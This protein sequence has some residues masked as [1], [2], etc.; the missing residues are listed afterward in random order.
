MP[1]PAPA[2]EGGGSNE[3]SEFIER[4]LEIQNKYQDLVTDAFQ[5]DAEFQKAMTEA[6][7]EFVNKQSEKNTTAQLIS[8]YVDDFLRERAAQQPEESVD[9]RFEEILR[10]LHHVIDRD[11]FQEFYRKQLAKR[12]LMG[13]SA[14]NEDAE[15]SFIL[16]LKSHNG[17][18][19]TNRLEGMFTDH[20]MASELQTDFNDWVKE[21]EM[22][23]SFEVQ[24]L[25]QGYW[26]S[27]KSDELVLPPGM[28]KAMDLFRE[29][30]NS[31][32]KNR[33]LTWVHTLGTAILSVRTAKGRPV[34]VTMTTYQGVVLLLFN[35]GATLTARQVAQL[36]KL[37][38]KEVEGILASLAYH[39]KAQLLTKTGEEENIAE[40]DVFAFNKG[41]TST[42]RHLKLPGITKLKEAEVK[43]VL[44]SVIQDRKLVI[45]AAVVRIMKARQKL[46]HAELVA[47]VMEQLKNFKPETK[48]IKAR[49]EDLITRLY[50]KRDEAQQGL[51]HYLA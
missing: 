8:V 29:F 3:V 10:L 16:K 33:Q 24:V 6:F 50:L 22:D 17:A 37:Q 21:R 47:E 2:A 51:Y 49:I 32:K 44:P 35:A 23:V 28:T 19:F 26:P 9:R 34:E 12:L 27:Y 38:P 11:L 4:L 20:T 7:Q 30:Y 36:T 13:G 1:T 48:M 25:T 40:E 39:K 45:E 41:F 42:A 18:A 5:G 14:L 46:T 31:K 15:K 43:G